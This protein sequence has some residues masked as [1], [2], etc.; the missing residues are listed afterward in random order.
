MTALSVLTTVAIA[1][2]ACGAKKDDKEEAKPATTPVV[3]SDPATSTNTTTTGTDTEVAKDDEED[4][5]DEEASGF[6][7]SLTPSQ[8]LSVLDNAV[9]S[10]VGS[11]AI[12]AAALR[13]QEGNDGD[14]SE[15]EEDEDVQSQIDE[16]CSIKS[17]PWDTESGERMEI[18]HAD[19]IMR[20]FYCKVGFDSGNPESARGAYTM[21][22]GILCA[23]DKAGG[24]EYSEEGTVSDRTV[25]VNTDCF[26]EPFVQSDE[27]DGMVLDLAVTATSFP[28]GSAWNRMV[29]FPMP[30][31]GGDE[32]DDEGASLQEEGEEEPEMM[33]L[34]F[35]NTG[36]TIAV[37]SNSGWGFS[38]DSATGSLRF[39]SIDTRWERHTRILAVGSIDAAT[40]ALTDVTD[41]QGIHADG[42]YVL[43]MS[44][45]RADGLRGR[46]WRSTTFNG[47]VEPDPDFADCQEGTARCYGAA[48]ATCEG[49]DGI[50]IENDAFLDVTDEMPAAVIEAPLSFSAVEPVPL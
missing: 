3:S 20:S 30:G 19:Y 35:S 4:E 5:E 41:I 49:N 23:L 36:T 6:S 22:K 29:S 8:M 33:E 24:L 2:S 47:G 38:L 25:T 11:L 46:L 40:G 12:D 13:L 28:E 44:G 32:G 14:Q 50:A 31:K 39:E 9:G 27:N 1:T 42:G 21:A 37:A 18:E 43:T 10:S 34:Y 45:A 48:S 15:N 16:R 26:S 7:A 17:S